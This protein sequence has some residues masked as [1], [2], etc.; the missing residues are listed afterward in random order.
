[1]VQT[2]KQTKPQIKKEIIVTETISGTTQGNGIKTKKE[3]YG[4]LTL[5]NSHGKQITARCPNEKHQ[6]PGLDAFLC[7]CPECRELYSS[8]I[9]WVDQQMRDQLLNRRSRSK[10][11][12]S[13]ADTES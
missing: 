7:K 13:H 9:W 12:G 2:T 1:M 8:G 11:T 4:E 5:I 10:S 3:G 6:I